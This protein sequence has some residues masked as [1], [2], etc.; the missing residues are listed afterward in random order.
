MVTD[1]R[2]VSPR[3]RSRGVPLISSGATRTCRVGG[4]NRR[5]TEAR[6]GTNG[7]KVSLF[8]PPPF[9]QRSRP[10]TR[11]NMAGAASSSD[12][13]GALC[14]LTLDLSLQA[15][16]EAE[17]GSGGSVDVGASRGK[18]RACAPVAALGRPWEPAWA[19]LQPRA[20]AAARVEVGA[21]PC[22]R[23]HNGPGPVPLGNWRQAL[24]R[25][26]GR[27]AAVHSSM[28]RTCVPAVPC[29]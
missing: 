17:A 19:E 1:L 16:R 26:L 18:A 12:A 21:P 4:E 13:P 8:G 2:R 22:V 25:A 10:R 14:S 28:R 29:V 20:P 6:V 9:G 3:S 23:G 15:P 5:P 27:T 24:C 7:G 11:A